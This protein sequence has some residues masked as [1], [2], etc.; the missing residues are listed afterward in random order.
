MDTETFCYYI[1]INWIK[2]IAMCNWTFKDDYG[3]HWRQAIGL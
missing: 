1:I 2:E 3:A